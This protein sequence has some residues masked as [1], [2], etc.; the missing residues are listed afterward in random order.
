M[1]EEVKN[2]SSMVPF[3]TRHKTFDWVGICS[4]D[5]SLGF[6]IFFQSDKLHR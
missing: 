5:L 1:E 4:L 2:S 6:N 3:S